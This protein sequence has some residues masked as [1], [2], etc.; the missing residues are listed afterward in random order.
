VK[1]A[2]AWR[3]FFAEGESAASHGDPTPDGVTGFTTFA[4]PE[5]DSRRF[6]VVELIRAYAQR[7]AELFH[8]ASEPIL[9]VEEFNV[10]S[11]SGCSC[12]RFGETHFDLKQFLL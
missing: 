2:N 7:R 3:G 11:R 4:Q 8:S 6:L 9:G 5:C 10:R 1:R 12:A